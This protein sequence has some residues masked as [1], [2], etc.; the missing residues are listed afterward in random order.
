MDMGRVARLETVRRYVEQ[1]SKGAVV[2]G[3]AW[4][5]CNML[6]SVTKLPKSM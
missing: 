4:L 6:W 2:P 5:R 3:L 1:V